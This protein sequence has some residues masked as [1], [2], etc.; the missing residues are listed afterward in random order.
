V[1]TSPHPSYWVE[2]TPET[3]YRPLEEDLAVDVA[4]IGGGITG[5]TASL[6][7]KQE[8]K[9]VALLEAKRIVRGATGYTTGKLTAGHGVVYTDLQKNFGAE[10]ARIY[11]E[12][13]QAAVRRVAQLVEEH[14]IACD[15]E[16]KANYVY[17]GSNQEVAAL[18]AEV[19]AEKRAGLPVEL[20]QETPLPYWVAAAI[21]L[22]D[23]AQFH[24]R[25]YLLAL[26]E[27]IPGEG[28]HVFEKTMAT[29][30]KSGD[31][32]VVETSRGT[33]RAR[34]V[35]I[36][37]H[38]P[39][40]DGGLFFVKA[41]PHRSYAVAA[42]LDEA[43]APDGMFINSGTPTR[44]VRT[45]QDGER[46]L[47]QVGGEGHRPGEEDDTA[48]RYQVLEDF[49]SESW[50]EAGAV[51]YRWSTQDY[52]SVDRVP[53]IG[54]LRRT[55]E[56]VYAATGYSKWGM[57]SGTLAGMLLTDQILGRPNPWAKLYE[58]KRITPKASFKRF[59]SGNASAGRHLVVDRFKAGEKELDA[60]KPG[61]GAIVRERGRKRAA[62]RD[63][64][65]ALHLLSP[66]CTHL[67]CHVV[68]NPAE[69]SW[70]CPC[71]GSRY[72]GEGDV[73]QGPAVKPLERVDDE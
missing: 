20:V 7:L 50:P 24:P 8:G 54:R 16:P 29:D 41:H 60:I 1:S 71:H 14:G 62:Y 25:K 5:I 36:A 52:M 53:Y 42:P 66:A 65:G 47:I 17:A 40:E 34:N 27:M 37:T 59:L 35:I 61:D 39:F 31:L 70:D 15:F 44:S 3:S 56:H 38:L 6:F 73:I 26:A 43:K 21:R 67:G 11:A 18:K 28:S 45:I 30:V 9:T 33:I 72:S 2:T 12:S 46:T 22:E 48:A 55:S 68:W 13:N 64:A 23:Q 58:A 10:G 4:V 51:E 63:E 57:T 32:C 69:R 19:E 49:L